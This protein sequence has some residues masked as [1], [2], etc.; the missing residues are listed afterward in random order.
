M[1]EYLKL[2]VFKIANSYAGK[3][4]QFSFVGKQIVVQK[5]D[6]ASIIGLAER[7]SNIDVSEPHKTSF[8]FVGSAL[9]DFY[10]NLNTQ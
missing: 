6:P 9:Y 10:K 3:H 2:E 7:C 5:F 8:R 1:E 4:G